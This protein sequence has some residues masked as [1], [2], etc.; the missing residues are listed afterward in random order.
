MAGTQGGGSQHNPPSTSGQQKG[1]QEQ[2]SKASKAGC[3]IF[4]AMAI[5]GAF[6][7]NE[8][9]GEPLLFIGLGGL[10]LNRILAWWHHS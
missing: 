4:A 7:L 6:S 1:G 8:D 3:L 5:I 9:M 10:V 2:T